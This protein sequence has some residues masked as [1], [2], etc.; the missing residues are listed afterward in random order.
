MDQLRCMRT[1]VRVAELGSFTRAAEALRLSRAVVSTQ[2]MEL[3][4]HLGCQLMQRT[5]RKVAL[6]VDGSHY[7]AQCR[8]LLADIEAT[9]EAMG[10]SPAGV[11]GRL[12]IGVPAALGRSWLTGALPEFGIRYPALQIE[13]LLGDDQNAAAELDLGIRLGAGR[14]MSLLVRRVLTTRWLTVASPAYLRSRAPPAE[15][16]QLLEGHRVIGYLEGGAPRALTFQH[17]A[18]RR[19]VNPPFALAFDSVDAQIEAAVRGAGIAQVLD[20]AAAPSL[21][22]GEL[23]PVLSHWSGAPVPV[24]TVRRDSLRDTLKVQALAD[25]VGELLLEQRRQLEARSTRDQG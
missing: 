2:V 15:P 23:E 21:A 18:Q 12:R 17:G 4:Q 19:R 8:R 11:H 7:L 25:F 14:G 1:F 22:R 13:L 9:D 5:T 16:Q 3:E 6:T 10:V 20:V 24:S